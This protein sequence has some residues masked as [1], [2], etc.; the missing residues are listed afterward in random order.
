[1]RILTSESKGLYKYRSYMKN[2]LNLA[3]SANLLLG[4]HCSRPL[5]VNV[6]KNN[7]TNSVIHIIVCLPK[8]E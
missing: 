2:A 1:M 6:F 4:R 5:F 8:I 3:A 7:I